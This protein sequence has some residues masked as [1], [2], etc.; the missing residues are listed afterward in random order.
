MPQ[1]AYSK[2]PII[3]QYHAINTCYHEMIFIYDLFYQ[4]RSNYS[5][6][7]ENGPS[8]GDHLLR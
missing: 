2:T 4:D 1:M 5:P 6:T 8:R 7:V 3:L